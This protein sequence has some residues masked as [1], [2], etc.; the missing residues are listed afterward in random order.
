MAIPAKGHTSSSKPELCFALHSKGVARDAQYMIAPCEH[1][2]C[3]QKTKCMEK[4]P[5]PQG[6][7]GLA[8]E[9]M[10]ASEINETQGITMASMPLG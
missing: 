6:L 9:P 7:R 3:A 8:W 5:Q 4:N 10:E 1:F 2:F